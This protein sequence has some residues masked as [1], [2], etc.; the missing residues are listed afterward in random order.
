MPG[1]LIPPER[2]LFTRSWPSKH[3][4]L[5][6][7]ASFVDILI[8]CPLGEVLLPHLSRKMGHLTYANQVII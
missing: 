4:A 2:S 1:L 7:L 5:C 6:D 3:S 8:D